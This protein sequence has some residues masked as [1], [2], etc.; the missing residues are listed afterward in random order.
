M[1]TRKTCI[2]AA[3]LFVLFSCCTL[4]QSSIIG[5]DL[6]S[7]YLKVG[8]VQSNRGVQVVHNEQ[9]KRKTPSVLAFPPD[10]SVL[11][12]DLAIASASKFPNRTAIHPLDYLT[13]YEEHGSL[14][15]E[16]GFSHGAQ[17]YA[18][19]LKQALQIANATQHSVAA[20]LVIP[21]WLNTEQRQ[22]V[23][24]ACEI[25]DISSAA[26]IHSNTA[27]AIKYLLDW[28]PEQPQVI[29]FIDIGVES[30]SATIVSVAYQS[31]QLVPQ[32][33]HL[34][35]KSHSWDKTLGGKYI[36]KRLAEWIL[37][38]AAAQ[39]QLG[40][41]SP[42]SIMNRA[43]CQT[44]LL[45]EAKRIKEILSINQE[46]VASLE[47]MVDSMDIQVPI[48]RQE[49]E[50]L[51]VDPESIYRL[52][53]HSLTLANLQK[54]QVDVIVPFGGTSRIPLIQQLLKQSLKEVNK[55]IHADE[56]AVYGATFFAALSSPNI[57]SRALDVKEW[58][59]FDIWIQVFD[60]NSSL[61]WNAPLV[62]IGEAIPTRKEFIL[63]P[64]NDF[65]IHLYA[66]RNESMVY[67]LENTQL[68]S[69]GSSWLGNATFHVNFTDSCEYSISYV[70][71]AFG[72]NI[73]G[74]ISPPELEWI[75][76]ESNNLTETFNLP[77]NS[78]V[79]VSQQVE[80]ERRQSKDIASKDGVL[81][82]FRNRSTLEQYKLELQQRQKKDAM[83]RRYS[84][85]CNELESRI[86][87]YRQQLTEQ[88]HEW[89]VYTCEKERQKILQNLEQ[90]E[91]WL[92]SQTSHLETSLIQQKQQQILDW[93][94]PIQERVETY[95]KIQNAVEQLN[96]TLIFAKQVLQAGNHSKSV[97]L[98][99][100]E[101]NRWEIWLN[102]KWNEYIQKAPCENS[103]AKV[104]SINQCDTATQTIL[105]RIS[106][107]YKATKPT[108]IAIHGDSP[109]N[110]THPEIQTIW[111]V[112]SE[113]DNSTQQTIAM[114]TNH[115][116]L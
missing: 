57:R 33:Y 12:G 36:D 25:A 72:V 96:S 8:R 13:R 78:S 103:R 31:K 110:D 11:F 85:M 21:P 9:S 74:F 87:L 56:A 58:Q 88:G 68:S 10:G 79:I 111:P 6:G 93:I 63:H 29:L 65:D 66:F 30:A 39:G 83:V 107:L 14:L 16:Q 109:D 99:Q 32:S 62:C 2:F 55:S 49:V 15:K 77:S 4:V 48:Y 114:E 64:K 50:S 34:Q 53:N 97:E 98:L 115:D 84:D 94:R 82:P 18:L 80:P 70:R 27:C 7:D 42:L 60:S 73:Q 45:Q 89:N 67:L 44:R 92:Y 90:L 113:D 102:N 69:N 104:L 59:T 1:T 116:E 24:F 20:G 61:I 28:R 86:L 5:I 26:L 101:V 95:H 19:F 108:S 3:L 46:T 81:F 47:N 23:L 71:M 38:K 54:E 43:K 41:H 106:E 52:V 22:N 105:N 51:L 37:Q 112:Q 40:A 17:M 76:T 100:S 75:C 35:V 91:H